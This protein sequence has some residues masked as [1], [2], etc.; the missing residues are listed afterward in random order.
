MRARDYQ[1]KWLYFD[2]NEKQHKIHHAGLESAC[3]FKSIWGLRWESVQKSGLYSAHW[4][5]LYCNE[6]SLLASAN[7]HKRFTW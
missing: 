3:T 7:R 5:G 6:V 4:E 2:A 1:G